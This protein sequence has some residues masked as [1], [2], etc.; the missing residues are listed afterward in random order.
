MRS[1]RKS[2]CC[3]PS[4]PITTH[5]DGFTMVHI[6]DVFLTN[7]SNSLAAGAVFLIIVHQFIEVN[8]KRE[9]EA[10]LRNEVPENS[11]GRP[12]EI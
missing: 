4:D 10:F 2:A 3:F 9:R 6:S 1:S 7:L 11:V 12:I 5:R 8:A